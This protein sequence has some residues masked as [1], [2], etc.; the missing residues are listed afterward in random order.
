MMKLLYSDIDKQP[1]VSPAPL[2]FRIPKF[3]SVIVF[4][5]Y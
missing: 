1:G 3:K 2:P 5:M 4:V